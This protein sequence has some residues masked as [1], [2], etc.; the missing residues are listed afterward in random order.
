[1]TYKNQIQGVKDVSETVKTVEKIAASS[2]HFLKQKVSNLNAYATEVEK[3]LIRLSLF[4][5]KKDH[6]LLQ[7]KYAGRKTLVILTGD[8]GLAGGLWHGVI[9][10]FL[11]NAKQYQAIIM[12]GTKGENYLKE[13]KIPII[14]LF[15]HFF[16]IPKKE[17]IEHVT[18]YI[19]NE[20]K[21][22]V[23]SR[24]DILYPQFVSLAEQT[25]NFTQ[26]LPFEFKLTKGK[27][28]GEGLPIFE[29]SKQKV[30]DKLL[31]KYIEIFF[32]KIIMETKLS[33]LSARTVAME[34]A[35]TKT[36]ELI[37]KL[38]LDYTK[39]RRRIVTQRQLESFA[40]HKI[41]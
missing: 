30:F 10:T 3:V 21:K 18:D 2:V 41:I 13:E 19:F 5:Q 11:E 35:A 8:K 39:E 37:Q 16:D 24:V 26:F 38:T 40:T 15:T 23:F 20:F 4:Y 29:P 14:K 17:E 9:N 22:E 33:E 36:E 6:L 1:M 25:P 28:N 34:H 7:K 27:K 31:Q 12:I 32:Y